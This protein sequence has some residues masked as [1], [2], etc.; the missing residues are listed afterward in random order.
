MQARLLFGFHFNIVSDK[1]HLKKTSSTS[2]FYCENY[3]SPRNKLLTVSW[4]NGNTFVS[5]AR[6]LRFKSLA[7]QIGYRVVNGSPP[8]QHFFER[9]SVACRSDGAEMDPKLNSWQG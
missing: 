6:G 8:L 3:K 7:G 2:S 9:N 1:K 4:S 5:G